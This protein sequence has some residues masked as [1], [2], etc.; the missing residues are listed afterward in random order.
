M[1]SYGWKLSFGN[2]LVLGGAI[3]SLSFANALLE[4]SAIAQI[5]P[6]GT[7]PNNSSVTTQ[8]NITT[9]SGGTEVGANLFHS[10][11]QFS[12]PTD[13]TAY[14]NNA[15]NIQ[16]I[17]S[18]VTGGSISNIN[19]LI[20]ANGNANLFLLNPNGIIFDS[21]AAL[22]IGGSFIASTA[23]SIKFADGFQFSATNPQTP[24]SLLTVSVPVG[25][26]LGSNP[27]K[28]VNSSRVTNS[29]G[30]IVGLSVQPGATLGLVGGEV[31]IAGG[32]MRAKGGRIELGS[33]A[34][35]NL[36]S[37]E[38]ANS[39]WLLD[40]QN[41]ANF[42]DM[43]LTDN[44]G[45]AVNGDGKGSININANK[46]DILSG[47]NLQ[48]GIDSNFQFQG[49]RAGEITLNARGNVSVDNATIVN[50]G[51]GIGNA[52]NINLAGRSVFFTNGSQLLTNSQR[53]G[54]A[55]NITIKALDTASFDG[56][57]SSG[58]ATTLA[59]NLDSTGRGNGG[60]IAIDAK[61]VFLSNGAEI[62][63]H[64]EGQGNAGSITINA[65]DAIL[66]DGVGSNGFS[67]GVGSQVLG[68]AVGDGGAIALNAPMV[69]ISGGANIVAHTHAW[70]NAG[71]VKINA[72]NIFLD[73]VGSN[74]ESSGLGSA[75][76]ESAQG[77]AG[78]IQIDT[79][80]LT[81]TNSAS[82]FVASFGRGDAESITINAK[83]AVSFDGI[84]SN[85]RSSNAF[86]TLEQG[87]T[88]NGKEIDIT[89]NSLSLTNGAVIG[90]ATNAQ[91]NG[92][93]I[94]IHVN[95]LNVLNGGQILTTSR[96]GGNAGNIVV[97]ATDSI[98]LSGS[99]PTYAE[100]LT[101]IGRPVVRN[102]GAASGLFAD[103]DAGS[104]GSG[105]NISVKTRSLSIA[106]D[107]LL[108]VNSSG[109][110]IAGDIEVDSRSIKLDDKARILATAASGN[111]GNISLKARNFLTL[112]RG[113]QISTT[114]GIAGAGGDGG[115]I[116]INNRHGFIV[117][118]PNENSDITANAFNGLGG[119]I[120][121]NS[122][123]IFGMQQLTRT[124]LMRLLET[125]NPT[126]LDPQQLTTNSI[127]AFSQTSPN[128]SGTINI[129][130]PEVELNRGLVNLPSVP[131]TTE[132][133]QACQPRTGDNQS[134][135]IVTGRGGL[136][137][138]PTDVL[139]NNNVQ[140]DWVALDSSAE[141]SAI[142]ESKGKIG[143]N[144][145]NAKAA[146]PPQNEIVEA[147][148]WILNGNG[149]ITLV[150]PAPTS[151]PH[152]SW[153]TPVACSVP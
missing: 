93:N 129:N 69:T 134:Q 102:Q 94:K 22:N 36:V 123:S 26:Q 146:N 96:N 58:E 54:S 56:V 89:A 75:A 91:G 149:N 20:R 145:Q 49:D 41:I 81:A 35:N 70:G 9:I 115:N 37:L 125:D 104:T 31:A 88:G 45:I 78:E 121:I 92:G 39:G 90:T 29:R 95:T 140:V 64:T 7:L 23:S 122:A 42:Q 142:D 84:G 30:E 21:N 6:D 66:I 19:G 107:A 144:W 43:S 127:T 60:K 73:G 63:A 34:A 53:Q 52:G 117:A 110:G 118:A 62:V 80:S 59:A 133:T 139:T 76:F 120:R 132:V 28:I 99:D 16:N 103:A 27:G 17:I 152:N 12:V 130:T 11:E 32:H 14:F 131:V 136:P 2:W 135:F 147:Q 109:Q 3:T 50:L 38:S 79:N 8:D 51:V 151:N 153:S 87:S 72:D 55:G 40:Y 44:A 124:D 15:T 85:G 1:Q 111:G 68:N 137:P 105:G 18:R 4:N 82:L 47:S 46:V 98:T 74:G 113:S 126:R 119:S 101:L 116:S 148:G 97:G 143:K 61:S 150:A 10:F 128:L 106:N 83:G 48:A 108:D 13:T 141:N 71:T 5:L 86:S 112:R 114:A 25:L 33:P 65:S 138:N 57:S 77:N 24:S 67:S 100:R